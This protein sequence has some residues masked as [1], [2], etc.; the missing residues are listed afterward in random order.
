MMTKHHCILGAII[1]LST[2]LYGNSNPRGFEAPKNDFNPIIA[3]TFQERCWQSKDETNNDHLTSGHATARIA[4]AIDRCGHVKE[5][6]RRLFTHYMDKTD[7]TWK[8][9]PEGQFAYPTFAHSDPEQDFP[10]WQPDYSTCAMP[11]DVFWLTVCTEGCY[12]PD[13]KLAFPGGQEKTL[14]AAMTAGDTKIMTLAKD[15]LF[16]GAMTYQ[17]Q[18]IAYFT[19]DRTAYEQTLLTF[20]T[21]SGRSLTVTTNHWLVDGQGYV[22]EAWRFAP[23]DAVVLEDGSSDSV[24]NITRAQVKTKVYNVAPA[25]HESADNIVVAQG[26]LNGSVRYQDGTLKDFLQVMDR[27]TLPLALLR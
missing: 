10:V 16:D 15:S 18:E 6:A 14:A 8:P 17:P 23:G 27:D 11:E 26:I 20:E 12:Q 21:E 3:A 19:R 4:W 25:S 9:R 5:S 22:T 24:T 7:W 1:G 2:N 13:Q